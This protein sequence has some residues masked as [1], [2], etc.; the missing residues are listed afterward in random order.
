MQTFRRFPIGVAVILSASLLVYTCGGEGRGVQGGDA[1]PGPTIASTNP[2]DLATEVSP[3]AVVSA[4]FDRDIDPAT[5]NESTFRVRTS[6]GQTVPGAVTVTGDTATFTPTDNL[7]LRAAHVAALSAGIADLAGKVME[8]DHS[9]TF[10]TRDG[11]WG[12]PGP[13]APAGYRV[14]T[15]GVCEQWGVASDP[16]GNVFAVWSGEDDSGRFGVWANR[17]SPGVGWDSPHSIGFDGSGGGILQ[18]AASGSGNA[19]TVWTAGDNVWANRYV[20]GA[21]WEGPA[22]VR[23]VPAPPG[24]GSVLLNQAPLIAMNTGGSAVAVW[25]EST[26]STIWDPAPLW[27][28]VYDPGTGWGAAQMLDNSAITDYHVAGPVASVAMDDTG[29]AIVSWV[30]PD[31]GGDFYSSDIMVRRY[32]AGSGW[33]VSEVIDSGG[34]STAPAIVADSRGVCTL[35]WDRTDT[36]EQASVRAAR[37]LPG[38]GW[39]APQPLWTFIGL[40]TGFRVAAGAGGAVVVG[41]DRHLYDGISNLTVSTTWT[42]RFD[43]DA[44]WDVPVCLDTTNQ[45]GGDPS[46][47]F[48]SVGVD[49]N[50]NAVAVW[51]HW[52]GSRFDAYAARYLAG[53]GWDISHPIEADDLTIDGFPHVAVDSK[54][55]ATAVWP[56]AFEGTQ[57]QFGPFEMRSSRF[58]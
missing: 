51:R 47:A 17:F 10:T 58:E 49:P 30:R 44:G 29:N 37:Y 54:G 38:I 50:G 45:P 52:D 26:W 24:G 8:S 35:V 40:I 31:P 32:T 15:C 11:T 3:G 13:I 7:A 34:V 1:D 55:R 6:T 57:S 16:A 36:P 22:L 20:A 56:Q 43:P 18:V 39:G 48:P 23:T 25:S 33:E 42:V 41:W 12:S 21:G 19:M 4:V 28:S 53:S 27:T 5:L 14:G 46:Y 9:W 2:E